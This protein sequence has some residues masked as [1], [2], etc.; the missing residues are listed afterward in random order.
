MH[1]KS[2][3]KFHPINMYSR[4]NLINSIDLYN[5]QTVL[6]IGSSNGWLI[7]DLKKNSKK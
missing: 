4:E 2:N 5:N 7:N 1:E 3:G 6:E